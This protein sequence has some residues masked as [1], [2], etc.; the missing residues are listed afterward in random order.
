MQT[1]SYTEER[2]SRPVGL[3]ADGP[4]MNGPLL[5]GLPV[6]RLAARFGRTTDEQPFYHV[7]APEWTHEQPNWIEPQHLLSATA[8]EDVPHEVLA[9]PPPQAAS[10][11]ERWR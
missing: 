5:A 6:E 7:T 2:P 11:W 9:A 3:D 10:L 1:R 8:F 4:P